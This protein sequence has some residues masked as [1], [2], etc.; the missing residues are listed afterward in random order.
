MSIG[1]I[2]PKCGRVNSPELDH[3][4]C[5]PVDI[6]PYNVQWV[7]YWRPLVGDYPPYGQTTCSSNYH[8]K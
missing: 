5:G 1:W 4:P 6:G 2:C 8:N 3:C 7:P